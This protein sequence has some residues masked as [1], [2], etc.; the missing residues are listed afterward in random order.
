MWEQ[1]SQNG[2][3]T[4]WEQSTGIPFASH[5]SHVPSEASTRTLHAFAPEH[6]DSNIFSQPLLDVDM[7][8]LCTENRT[9]FI[10]QELDLKFLQVFKKSLQRR[11]RN[12]RAWSS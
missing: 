3:V 8:L 2:H 12:I 7:A 5:R 10:S 9:G 11:R 6:L 4:T 1:D